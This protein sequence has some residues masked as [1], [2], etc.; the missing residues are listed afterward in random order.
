MRRTALFKKIVTRAGMALAVAV[1]ASMS[2]ALAGTKDTPAPKTK[3]TPKPFTYSGYFRSYYFTRQNASAGIPV[4]N[5]AAFN[6][7]L[8]LHGEYRFANSPFSLGA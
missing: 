6:A 4:P 5:Q 3:A 8:S 2:M 1:L 7:A